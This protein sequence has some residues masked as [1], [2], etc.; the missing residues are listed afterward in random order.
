[1]SQ[2][3]TEGQ[4]EEA[5]YGERSGHVQLTPLFPDE[6]GRIAGLTEDWIEWE[7]IVWPFSPLVYREDYSVLA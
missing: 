2:G 5:L 4:V 6:F 7:R 1:M 3:M